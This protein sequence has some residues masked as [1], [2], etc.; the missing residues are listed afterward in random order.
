[1][2]VRALCVVVIIVIINVGIIAVMR[3]GAVAQRHDAPHNVTHLTALTIA[4]SHNI[5]GTT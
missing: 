3:I 2:I 4:F 5:E 1:V